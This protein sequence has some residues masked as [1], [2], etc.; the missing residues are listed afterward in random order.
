MTLPF[1]LSMPLMMKQRPSH[2]ETPGR[3]LLRHLIA[4]REEVQREKQSSLER[5]H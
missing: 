5:L 4:K 2:C 3:D 1:K